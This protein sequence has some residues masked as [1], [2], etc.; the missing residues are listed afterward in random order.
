MF[1]LRRSIALVL[2]PSK[3]RP[4]PGDGTIYRISTPAA[5]SICLISST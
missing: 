4:A 3:P 1:T 2:L 5:C